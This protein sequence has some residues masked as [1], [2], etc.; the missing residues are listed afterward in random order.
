MLLR[1][2]QLHLLHPSPIQISILATCVCVVYV[3]T[4]YNYNYI[5]VHGNPVAEAPWLNGRRRVACGRPFHLQSSKMSREGNAH[6]EGGGVP[7]FILPNM[8]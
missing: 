7:I 3:Y 8:P 2:V 6:K 4:L 1:T 5:G